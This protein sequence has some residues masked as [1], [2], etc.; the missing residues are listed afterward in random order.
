MSS[1]TDLLKGQE[2]QSEPTRTVTSTTATT[3]TAPTSDPSQPLTLRQ[4]AEAKAAELDQSAKSL[5][6]AYDQTTGQF[7]S[8]KVT[9]EVLANLGKLSYYA[10]QTG[11]KELRNY[12]AQNLYMIEQSGVTVDRE[13]YGLQTVDTSEFSPSLFQRTMNTVL[14]LPVVGDTLEYLG[15]LSEGFTMAWG[16]A[17]ADDKNRHWEMLDAMKTGVLG[18]EQKQEYLDL[19]DQDGDGAV[20]FREMLGLDPNTGEI[21]DASGFWEHLYN[22]GVGAVDT[23]GL[24]LTDPTTYLTLGTPTLA[25][26]GLE[27][28]EAVGGRG[29]KQLVAMKGLRVMPQEFQDR[30]KQYMIDSITETYQITGKQSTLRK[31]ASQF[32]A[33]QTPQT[34]VSVAGSKVPI[35]VLDQVY[36]YSRP[37]F[38]RRYLGVDDMTTSGMLPPLQGPGIRQVA[39]Q[40]DIPRV[41]EGTLGR[42]G[43]Q[44]IPIGVLEHFAPRSAISRILGTRVANL[45]DDI[46]V[47]TQ[48]AGD[49][50]LEDISSQ[51]VRSG[52]DAASEWK[53]KFGTKSLKE[54]QREVDLEVRE[55]LEGG[56]RN[57]TS[58]AEQAAFIAASLRARGLPLVAK[59]VETAVQMRDE[60]TKVAE[61]AGLQTPMAGYFPRQA[62]KEGTE[63]FANNSDAALEFGFV[64]DGAQRGELRYH[65]PRSSKF[66]GRT[67]SEVNDLLRS[68]YPEIPDG[69]NI[70]EEDVLAAFATRGKSAYQAA[71]LVDMMDGLTRELYE[72]LPLAIPEHTV[73]KAEATAL[74]RK[75]YAPFVTPAGTYWMPREISS[76]LSNIRGLV[77]NDEGLKKL[78]KWMENWSKTWGAWATSP[79]HKGTGF[80]ARNHVGN[81]MLNAVAGI[82]DVKA[83]AAAARMQTVLWSAKRKAAKSGR[84]VSDELAA[85]GGRDAAVL[86]AAR[87]HQILNGF[88]DDIIIDDPG[89]INKITTENPLMQVSRGFGNAIED[90]AR[91]TH[92]IHQL[93]NGMSPQQAA[94]SVRTTLFDYGDLTGLERASKRLNRFYTFMRKNTAFQTM[95]LIK[96]PGRVAQLENRVSNQAEETA[97]GIL[98][99]GYS[100]ARGDTITGLAPGLIA[101]IDTPFGAAAETLRPFLLLPDMLAGRMESEDVADAWMALVAGGPE[102][103]A[104][105][106]YSAQT[107]RDP[108]TKRELDDAGNEYWYRKLTDSL[109]GPAWGA[110]DSMAAR[111]SGGEGFGPFG[112][113]E[114]SYTRAGLGEEAF[115]LSNI[116]G[117]NVAVVGNSAVTN[118]QHA[119]KEETAKMLEDLP[120][121]PTVEQFREH[122]LWAETATAGQRARSLT[123]RERILDAMNVGLP[124]EALEA[125]LAEQLAYE[126]DKGYIIDP[127]TGEFTT[128]AG[129]LEEYTAERGL[130]TPSG[131]GSTGKAAKVAW[132]QENPDDP[133][134]DSDGTPLDEYDLEP[135]WYE[136]TQ[137]EVLEWAKQVGAPLTEAGNVGMKTQE[138]WNAAFPDNPYY[139]KWSQ[140]RM[141]EEGLRPILGV[142]EYTDANGVT[143]TVRADRPLSE[144]LF[145]N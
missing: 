132:N 56:L 92:F 137:S 48:G 75:G 32:D 55:A 33:I 14:N 83:Y 22:Y 31:G 136:A 63:F 47:A 128:R 78:N 61:S 138:A 105:T 28:V 41:P 3:A 121:L 140:K 100:A 120:D 30:V 103:L 98:Q 125:E 53:K 46:R 111:A 21:D 72:G 20:N 57:G 131:A 88:F 77:L 90:N 110:F 42:R 112:N 34:A 58:D 9:P 85:M 11:D 10:G 43:I 27:A 71:T 145:G 64:P 54:A 6:A 73:A 7:E 109:I 87:K 15:D 124:T 17:L 68:H 89:W 50:A 69:V 123:L 91:L 65:E 18:R 76:E 36:N 101:S 143:H 115:V 133:F 12:V 26:A 113:Q 40:F 1:L 24:A 84:S 62:T 5:T 51:L 114:N 118:F 117:M 29:A 141:A 126:E 95:A 82:V 116:L 16:L 108:F 37:V 79:L 144:V 134:L 81:L 80:H 97:L 142:F 49:V 107:G 44:D 39:D 66:K 59:H 99:P 106:L 4:R 102:A 70:F 38:G 119:L 129:R 104:N 96:H 86:L 67:T 8:S 93:D 45:V 23:I 2:E 19:V 52:K 130:T 127:E 74:R 122:G 25:R 60:L 139:G 35:P 94:R 135:V 13:A